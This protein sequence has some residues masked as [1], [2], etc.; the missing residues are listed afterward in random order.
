LTD[1]VINLSA[2]QIGLYR[3]YRRTTT[4]GGPQQPM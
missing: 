1:A 3:I 4:T 2:G